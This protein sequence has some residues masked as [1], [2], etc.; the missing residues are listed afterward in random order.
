MSE[1]G[2]N[3]CCERNPC[4]PNIDDE[5]VASMIENLIFQ[6]FGNF[7]RTI[8]NGRAVWTGLCSPYD[9]GIPALPRNAD[10]GLLCYMIR[11]YEYLASS[12]PASSEPQFTQA[13]HGFTVGQAIYHDGT[14]F[15]LARAD[16][17][18]TSE[19]VGLVKAVINPNT[20]TIACGGWFDGLAGLVPGQRY[21][22]D[23]V[24]AGAL[25]TTEP[26]TIGHVSKPVAIAVRANLLNI[27][28][29]RG[30]VN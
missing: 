12:V 23:P 15:A 4:C 10:E 29:L 14:Q 9:Q 2:N 13:L 25:T 16:A 7:T 19:V 28:I 27:Q 17:A 24:T 30:I 8:V 22:L 21:W 26:T 3:D 11:L 5:S 18:A 1:C 6:M 20:F